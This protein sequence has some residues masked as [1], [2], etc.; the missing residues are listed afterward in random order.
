MIKF[1][2]PNKQLFSAT[3]I[4]S[5]LLHS[6]ILLT[7]FSVPAQKLTDEEL[8]M[9]NWHITNVSLDSNT[10]FNQD[11]LILRM[12]LRSGHTH[13]LD[14]TTISLYDTW[15]ISFGEYHD[16]TIYS[17]QRPTTGIPYNR[18]EYYTKM[19]PFQNTVWTRNCKEIILKTGIQTQVKYYIDQY[20]HLE[21]TLVKIE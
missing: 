21:L 15:I 3:S 1:G 17:V 6:I 11:T 14:S 8:H 12:A 10:I 16:L 4:A 9:N 7:S 13:Y 2:H 19:Y 5:L 20:S 18:S